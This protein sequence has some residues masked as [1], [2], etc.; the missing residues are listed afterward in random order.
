MLMLLPESGKD[1]TKFGSD[2]RTETRVKFHAGRML[3]GRYKVLGTI[4]AD[5]FKA[6][7]ILLDQTVTLRKEAQES[8]D[9]AWRRMVQE[10]AL[11]RD[12]NFLNVLDLIYD[13]SG[14]FVVTERPRGRSVAELLR[15][16]FQ[17]NLGEVLGMISPLAGA[18]DLAAA[19][20]CCPETIST[21][22]LFAE[23]RRRDGVNAGQLL[24]CEWPSFCLK[25]DL[26]E[27]ARP[28][29]IANSAG[30]TKTQRS[31][32]KALGVRLGALLIYELLCG[33]QIK[34]S[35]Q[36]CWF[37][38]V[39]ELS[40]AANE[41]LSYGLKGSPLFDNCG[42]FFRRLESA[43]LSIDENLRKPRLQTR[44]C[45]RPET[46]ADDVMRKFN[47][48]TRR[49]ATRVFAVV[50][51]VLLV[52]AMVPERRPVTAHVEGEPEQTGSRRVLNIR[53]PTVSGD[54]NGIG[55]AAEMSS[56]QPADI[57]LG[58]ISPEENSYL[59]EQSAA[60]PQA[61][62]LTLASEGSRSDVQEQ[63]G[64]WLP[65]HR[66]VPPRAVRSHIPKT[67]YVRLEPNYLVAL[68]NRLFGH[69]KKARGWTAFSNSNKAEKKRVGYTAEVV[70]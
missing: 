45:S 64:A 20:S 28:D 67:R 14:D 6:H 61:P 41:I 7:D 57:G 1:E 17:F 12:P 36:H 47:R 24:V 40:E 69:N 16:G 44:D 56:G 25:L 9:G 39:N 49:L 34:M 5:S 8:G 59:G 48:D 23:T 63:A 30:T 13:E 15:E 50:I 2:C 22:S 43:N 29:G 4:D 3:C 46:G 68:W 58:L 19:S 38:P 55:S 37:K 27:F 66:R 70:H 11:V 51:A 42:C 26:W 53:F 60:S 33:K 10:L 18:L 65:V 52:G 31:D 54:L 21:C 32:R 35:G 62:V